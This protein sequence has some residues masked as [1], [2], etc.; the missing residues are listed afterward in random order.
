MAK[1]LE[2]KIEAIVERQLKEKLEAILPH[3]CPTCRHFKLRKR[4]TNLSEPQRAPAYVCRTP[5]KVRVSGMKFLCWELDMDKM[6][7]K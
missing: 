4:I 1:R 2:D 3:T 6:R 5:G 7:R